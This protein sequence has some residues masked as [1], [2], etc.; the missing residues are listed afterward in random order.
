MDIANG[1]DYCGKNQ[2][3]LLAE[4]ADTE[5]PPLPKT[6]SKPPPSKK[7]GVN[8][9]ETR[10]DSDRDRDNTDIVGKISMLF[11][12]RID[13]LERNVEK[14]ISDNTLKIEGLKK[15]VDFACAEIRD[16]KDKVTLA[17]KRISVAE[18]KVN[19]IEQR[20]GDLENYTRRW[21][22]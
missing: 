18:K 12:T 6:P 19:L 14:L 20:L 5:F 1:H 16:V 7:R 4:M 10:P 15:T 3:V 9:S 13:A 11:N 22:L 21:S 2:P 17:E 8:H